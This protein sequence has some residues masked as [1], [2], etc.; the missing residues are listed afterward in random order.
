MEE[1][2]II[3]TKRTPV[4]KILIVD[5]QIFNINA[6][7]IILQHSVKIDSEAICDTAISGKIALDLVK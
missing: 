7:M 1:M 6:L 5:D 2:A 3:S 4:K